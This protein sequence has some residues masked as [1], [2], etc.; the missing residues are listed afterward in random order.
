MTTGE[1]SIFVMM[2]I[3][4]ILCTAIAYSIGF[5]EGRSEGYARGRAMRSHVSNKDVK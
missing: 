4:L 5:R 3:S 2:M 1:L